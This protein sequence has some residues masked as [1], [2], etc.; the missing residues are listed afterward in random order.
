MFKFNIDDVLNRFLWPNQVS[1]FPRPL[2]RFLGGASPRPVSDLWLWLE[3]LV[4]TFCGISVIEGVFKSHTVFSDHHAPLII[5]SYGA[6]AI[7]CFNAHGS[8]LAQPRNVVIGQVLSSVIGICIQKLFLLSSGGRD[9]YWAG[10]AL[11]VAILSVAMSVFNCV[12]PPGGASALLPCADEQIRAMSWWYIPAQLVSSVLML[13]VACIFG[14]IVRSYP[15][16]WWSGGVMGKPQEKVEKDAEDIVL[17]PSS[18]RSE[19]SRDLQYVAGLDR[20]EITSDYINIPIG[21][22]LGNLEKDWL[23]SLQNLVSKNEK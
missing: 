17:L 6:S 22:E 23:T 11:S 20:I 19:K 16:F 12:H 10:G 13:A 8:P 4:S 1:R 9:N 18:V 2:A 14:N 15:V 5:A 3:I 7:L 21:M